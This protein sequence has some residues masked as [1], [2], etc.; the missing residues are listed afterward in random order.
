MLIDQMLVD[1]LKYN[2][3]VVVDGQRMSA[4]D[5]AKQY[6]ISEKIIERV[7]VEEMVSPSSSP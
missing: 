2:Y 7:F 6:G 1:A 4:R 5:F 3:L